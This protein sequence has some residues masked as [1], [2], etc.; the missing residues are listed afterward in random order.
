[1]DHRPIV[2]TGFTR[3]GT[4]L[5]MRLLHVGGIEPYCPA[6]NIGNS[7]ESPDT[8]LLPDDGSWIHL[9]YGK[10]VKILEPLACR[11]PTLETGY[12]FIV[13]RRD[14]REQVKS[15]EK[16]LHLV[17]GLPPLTSTERR[18]L[19][20]SLDIDFPRML[21]R[22]E[23]YRNSTVQIVEFSAVLGNPLATCEIVCKFVG[24]PLD[25]APHMA[26][27]VIPRSAA[28]YPGLLELQVVNQGTNP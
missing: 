17:R 3:C 4:S 12:R 11:P 14:H 1:M 22:L 8:L 21:A 2:V 7:Y 28:C 16:F 15:M 25:R 19:R 13:M 18:R 27:V 23:S 5:M 20:R 24:L 10:A 9:C 26:D 6:E